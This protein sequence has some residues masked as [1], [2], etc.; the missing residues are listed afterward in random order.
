MG[1][2]VANTTGRNLNINVPEN[3]VQSSVPSSNE[4]ANAILRL[5]VELRD[6]HMV[7]NNRR[8]PKPRPPPA[9]GR[10]PVKQRNDDCFV[11]MEKV[12]I[13]VIKVVEMRC[14]RA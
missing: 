1:P 9:Y 6:K 12:R 5:E 7:Q 4:A 11:P 13:Y 2:A 14:R 10:G 8:P 3:A